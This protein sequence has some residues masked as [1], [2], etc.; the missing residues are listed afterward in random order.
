MNLDAIKKKITSLLEEK[1]STEDFKGYFLVDLV[2]SK[3]GRV[4]IFV[5]YE[6]GGVTLETCGKI[7]RHIEAYLDESL[8]LSEKYTLEVSSPGV[9]RALIKRQ[10]PKNIGRKI[11][12]ERSDGE[13][14]KGKLTAVSDTAITI[15]IV[16]SKKEQKSVEI[17]FEDIVKSLIIVSF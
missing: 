16:V 15:E 3:S 9:E 8:V 13:I 6:Q 7:S 1:F 2:I 12:V 17:L 14:L 4:Q 5:D 11:K 10:Y